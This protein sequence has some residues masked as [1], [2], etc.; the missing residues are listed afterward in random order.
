MYDILTDSKI[1]KEDSSSANLELTPFQEP[2][3]PS[4]IR[5]NSILMNILSKDI[6]KEGSLDPEES[7]TLIGIYE[8]QYHPHHS[9]HFFRQLKY[10]PKQKT[11]RMIFNTIL[12]WEVRRA[13]HSS[14]NDAIDCI[15]SAASDDMELKKWLLDALDWGFLSNLKE[16]MK[17]LL[18]NFILSDNLKTI[19]GLFKSTCLIFMFYWDMLKDIA[20]F[21]LFNHMSTNI[22]VTNIISPSNMLNLKVVQSLVKPI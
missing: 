7:L 20:T 10:A 2:I 21:A 15:L 9:C 5:Y 1:I 19:F 12:N 4:Q 8:S 11:A 16:S 22:L 3:S 6:P 13:N 14:K 17:D 18:P